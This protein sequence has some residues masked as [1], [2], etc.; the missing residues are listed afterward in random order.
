MGAGAE[1]V[2]GVLGGL[3]DG[4]KSIYDIYTNERDYDYQKALQQVI[5]NRED[6]AVQRR[7]KDLEAAGLN[8][9]LAAGSAASA[10]AVVGRSN[11][12]SISGNPIGTAL[13]TASAVMQL[14]NLREQN[15]V[16]R[17]Q[18]RNLFYD[19]YNKEIDSQLHAAEAYKMLGY[20]VVLKNNNGLP[21]VHLVNDGKKYH[22]LD[23]S[24]LG[25]IIKFQIQNNKNSADLL[26]KDVDFYT[27]DKIAEYFGAGVKAFGGIGQGLYSFGK[28]N[29]YYHK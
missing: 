20:D 11:T 6:T 29:K 12:P 9:N 4:V 8:P 1:I 7:R 15:Q 2:A 5:F 24:P 21:K 22:N 19:A 25:D 10:G 26:Q 13:D 16:L 14:R 3:F 28:Y 18:E 17:N 27:A 23:D